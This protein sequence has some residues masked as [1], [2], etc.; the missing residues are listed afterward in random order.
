M[1]G[2]A[3]IDSGGGVDRSHRPRARK[4]IGVVHGRRVGRP[5]REQTSQSA[6]LLLRGLWKEKRAMSETARE[7]RTVC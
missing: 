4:K 2:Q 6:R 5:S 1:E 3:K 7:K